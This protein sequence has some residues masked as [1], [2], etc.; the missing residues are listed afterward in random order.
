MK[1]TDKNLGTA[2]VSLEWYDDAICNFICNNKGYQIID[3]T[4][5]KICLIRQV[6]Q[7]IGIANTDI[8][9]DLPSLRKY[10]VSQLPGLRMDKV[11]GWQV[12]EPEKWIDELTLTIP[13]FNGLPKIHKSPWAICPIVPCHSVI[14]QPASQMLLIILKTLLP[15]FPW[16]LISSKHLCQDIEC[17]ESYLHHYFSSF[18]PYTSV[19]ISMF[20]LSSRDMS[21]T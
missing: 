2:L 9:H 18:F 4:I 7:I 13:L 12:E 11:T 8:T 14:Q 3:P 17:N 19:P 16:I 6:R 10:L 15:R 21:L 5:T 1:P 20:S